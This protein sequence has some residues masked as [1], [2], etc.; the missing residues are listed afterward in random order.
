MVDC[1]YATSD[2]VSED[3]AV[4]IQD[5][6][7]VPSFYTEG[8]SCDA[9]SAAQEAGISTSYWHYSSYCNTG[10]WFGNRTVPTDTF[11]AYILGWASGNSSKCASTAWRRR[12]AASLAKPAT[13]G[14]R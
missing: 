6:W 1:Y 9:W 12:Q 4:A 3:N 10:P 5:A 11:G 14:S 7:S 13:A 2:V 8:M